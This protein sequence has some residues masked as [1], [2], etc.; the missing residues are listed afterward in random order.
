LSRLWDVTEGEIRIGGVPIQDY[1]LSDLRTAIG[2]VPQDP[3]LFSM[4]IGENIAI[5]KPGTEDGAIRKAAETAGIDPEI[6]EFPKGYQTAVGE[7]GI[8]LSGGQKQRTA[9]ARAILRQ[10]EI[11]VLDDALS[12]VDTQTEEIVLR[13]LKKV[14]EHR[15]T[16]VVAHRI[17]TIQ[18]ADYIIVLDDGSILEQGTH[19][20]LLE[21]NGLYADLYRKQ[22]LQE[23]LEEM[24]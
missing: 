11:L 14:M 5:G 17:S 15:T 4:K 16:L 9:L 1:P 23:A 20:E 21:A 24:E 7:R 8:T 12:S 6:Q 10:P 2:A 19:S 13:G 22:Q 3:L 18:D